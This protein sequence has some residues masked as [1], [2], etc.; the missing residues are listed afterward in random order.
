MGFLLFSV[1]FV[2][3]ILAI[4]YMRGSVRTRRQETAITEV[5]D[6]EIAGD[7][8]ETAP[9]GYLDI[10]RQGIVKRVNRLECKLRGLEEHPRCS[11]SIAPI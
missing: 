4:K 11:A 2:G 5:F 9:I 3:L 10:D 1:C 8:F 7:L 6:G